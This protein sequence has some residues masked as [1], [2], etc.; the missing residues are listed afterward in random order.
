MSKKSRNLMSQAAYA[1]HAGLSPST[2]NGYVKDGKIKLYDGMVDAIEADKGRQ[3]NIAVDA[4]RGGKE[5][6]AQAAID[7]KPEQPDQVGD[8][9]T[10]NKIKTAHESVKLQTANIDLKRKQGQLVDRGKA[11]KVFFSEFRA[12]RDSFLNWPS[13]VASV[14]A[15]DLGVEPKLMQEILDKYIRVQLDDLASRDLGAAITNALGG[16]DADE[17]DEGLTANSAQSA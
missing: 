5:V 16:E 15:G 4:R 17:S 9:L 12:V 8:G 14:M 3:D 13:R 1:R 7:D 11:Q 6:D 2:I 10:L